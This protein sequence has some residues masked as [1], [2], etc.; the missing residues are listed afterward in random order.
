MRTRL[1][2]GKS[3]PGPAPLLAA[4]LDSFGEDPGRTALVEGGRTLSWSAFSAEVARIAGHLGSERSQG[5]IGILLPSGGPFLSVFL[6]AAA[7]GRPACTLHP[8]WAAPELEAAIDDAGIGVVFTD[9]PEVPGGATIRRPDAIGHGLAGEPARDLR[10]GPPEED[11]IF[12]VGF[13]SGT[14][15]RPKPFARRQASWAS[16][17]GP[18][19]EL[20]SVGRDDRVFLPGSLQHSH[21]LFGAV[22]ALSRGAA[23]RLF[24]RF[25]PACL[26]D[27]LRLESRAAVYLV[28]TMLLAID[29][30]ADEPLGGVHSLVISGAK[31]EPHHWEI[32]RRLFPNARV[33]ELYGASELSFVAVNTLGEQDDPGH[34][35]R[36]FPGVE[37][38]IRSQDGRSDGPG[39]VYVRSPYLFEGY[40]EG[41]GLRSP[42]DADG[43]VTV[44]DV[45]DFDGGSLSLTG[46]ASN[47]I[48]TGGKNVHP[49]E[50]ETH[51]NRLPAIF[52]CVV[53]G[54]PH[55][56]WGEEVVAFVVPAGDASTLDFASVRES[57][58]PLVAAY[59]IPK[60]WFIV[61]SIP[62][63]RAGK[64]DRD[65]DRLLEGAAEAETAA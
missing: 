23:V 38:K 41:T 25:D 54:I 37:I 55:R 45:G 27:E 42:A 9:R 12:Y 29:D 52:E 61:E 57:L 4:A 19:G 21:F 31:M 7:V 64:T 60:R 5:A 17:F 35:G 22:F 53:A 44:G 6:A 18:A 20:F 15:G 58:R 46:R 50:V 36:P 28:P 47:L 10:V 59:K 40:L 56:H 2:E 13:T 63:T 3:A 48:I 8:D 1:S 51:L 24:E 33:G 39:L 16:S 49:E 14:S 62:R 65:R 30:L 34:V 43:F 11:P 26:L 32:A